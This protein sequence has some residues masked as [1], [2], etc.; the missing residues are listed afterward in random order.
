MCALFCLF[1]QYSISEK[2]L[3]PC[4]LWLSVWDWD[5]FGRNQFL[6]EVRIP[7]SSVDLSDMSD[8][9]HPLAEVRVPG[10]TIPMY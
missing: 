10:G 6:G 5:R 7:L 2:K 9:W 3:S 4:T 8:H 1:L